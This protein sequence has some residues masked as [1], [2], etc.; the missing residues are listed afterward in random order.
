VLNFGNKSCVSCALRAL[1]F[2]AYHCLPLCRVL[3]LGLLVIYS[4]H[5]FFIVTVDFLDYI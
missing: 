2:I 4:L 5:S 1:L 3:D